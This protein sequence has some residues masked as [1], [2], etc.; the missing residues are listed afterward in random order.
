MTA[1]KQTGKQVAN[2]TKSTA[3]SAEQVKKQLQQQAEGIQSRI[4]SPESN[5]ISIKDKVFTFPDGQ[6]FNEALEVV[7]VDFLAWNNYYPDQFDPKNPKPPVCFAYGEDINSLA[8]SANAPE[9]QAKTCA[10]CW[11]N[12]F[13]S[14]VG[15]GKAC[16]NQRRLA[17]V[18]A[19]AED[20]EEA[21]M[22]TISVPPSSLK[23]FD[24]YVGTVA[25][26]YNV[27]PVGVKTTI[28]M[29][30]ESTYSMLL[31]ESPEPNEN[32]AAHYNRMQEARVL[33]EAEPDLSGYEPPK[34]KGAA[35]GR[36]RT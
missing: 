36:K 7:V 31:F 34:K 35:R 3:M 30:P 17:V 26:L 11:A 10:E 8:P 12:E 18:M 24:G 4:Q 14:G 13:G 15:D 29:H 19:D 25:R 23:K 5:A 33:L 6:I 27:P 2:R 21:P 1:R 20:P 9:P 22:Y 32:I 28:R 16:K